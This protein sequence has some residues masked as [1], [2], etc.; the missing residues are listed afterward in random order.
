[1]SFDLCRGLGTCLFDQIREISYFAFSTNVTIITYLGMKR[2][3]LE[4]L[5]QVFALL[6]HVLHQLLLHWGLN[7]GFLIYGCY[8]NME[9]AEIDALKEWMSF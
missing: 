2:F 3:F 5:G 4:F 9:I 1:M 8:L 6:R 7:Q